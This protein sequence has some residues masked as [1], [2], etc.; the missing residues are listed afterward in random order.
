MFQP[1]VRD[2]SSAEAV[3][4]DLERQPHLFMRLAENA[5]VVAENLRHNYFRNT[6]AFVSH[7]RRAMARDQPIFQTHFVGD[8]RWLDLQ[9]EV[10]TFIDGGVGQ[11]QLSNRTPIL[12]RV[13]SYSV[14]TGERS[15]SERETFGYYPIILGDLEGGTRTRKDFIDIVR[16][17]AELLGGLSALEQ[18]PHLDVLMFHGPLVNLLDLYAGHSPF[19]ESD[20]DLFLNQ[21]GHHPQSARLLKE[22]FLIEARRSIYPRLTADARIWSDRRLFEPLSW[23]SFLYRRLLHIAKARSP[24]PLIIGVVEQEEMRQFSEH[25]VLP[26]VF[27]GLADK[28]NHDYFITMYGRTD[29]TS[30]SALLDRLGYSDALL[31][32][33]LLDPGHYSEPWQIDK[34]QAQT[35]GSIRLPGDNRQSRVDWQALHPPSPVGFPAVTGCYVHVSE[36]T[37]PIRIEVFSDLAD[38]QIEPAARRA[39]LYARLLPGYGFPVGLEIADKYAHVPTWLTSAYGKL[40][41]YHL[42]VSLQMGEISDAQMQRLMVQAMYVTN[43]D[44]LFRP[45]S[46]RAE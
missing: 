30:A 40:I 41:R 5:L 9:G 1:H 3:A 18:M 16:I 15:L 37:E 4:S 21:Y 35:T 22:E 23:I 36:M 7:L 11:V 20:I 42:S 32:A 19:T 46:T 25:I 28:R 39:Y 10:V 8:T 27:R 24:K 33:L 34:T 44:W 38:E 17:T 26:R 13:G 29:L 14:R 2:R 43:R 12:L 45:K 31:L 6:A